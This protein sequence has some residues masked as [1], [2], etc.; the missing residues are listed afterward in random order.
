MK[1][2]IAKTAGVVINGPVETGSFDL[3]VPCRLKWL[4]GVLSASIDQHPLDV[5]CGGPNDI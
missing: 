3:Y 4:P 1:G 2:N 5:V